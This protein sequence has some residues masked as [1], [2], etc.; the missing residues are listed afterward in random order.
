MLEIKDLTVHYPRLSRIALDHVDFSVS[1]G[2]IVALLGPNGAGKTTLMKAVCGLIAPASGSVVANGHDMVRNPQRGRRDIGVLLYPE[3]S[4]YFRLTA[5]Q[6]LRFYASLVGLTGRRAKRRID[7]LLEMTGLN[8]H[9]RMP[10]MKYSL[11]MRKQLGLARAL[12]TDP[13][14]LLLDEPTANLDPPGQWAFLESIEALRDQGKSILVATHHLTDAERVADRVAVLKDGQLVK[15]DRTSAFL[16]P[17]KRSTVV[18]STPEPVPD[19]RLRLALAGEAGVRGRLEEGGV[20]LEFDS[21]T[22]DIVP[23]LSRLREQGISVE[24]AERRS[25]SLEDIFREVVGK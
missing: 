24:S 19:N 3:R 21:T 13:K 17:T 2:E 20:V 10:F 11:G 16:A 4:F 22:P 18:I 7:E 15:V 14:L 5:R 1:D 12:L 23:S 6:N 8:R 9:E 25:T